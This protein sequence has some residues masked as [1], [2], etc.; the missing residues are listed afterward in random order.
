MNTIHNNIK[1][2]LKAQNK[3]IKQLYTC[4]GITK[5]AFY[6]RV[7]GN[8]SIGNLQQIADALGVH[9]TELLKDDATAT[10]NSPTDNTATPPQNR[11]VCPICNSVLSVNVVADEPTTT[12]ATPAE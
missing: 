9:I 5:P 2:L 12:T 7:N 11:I 3:D 8:M 4:L 6:A 1:R 10:T